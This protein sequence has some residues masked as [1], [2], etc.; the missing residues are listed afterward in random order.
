MNK[1]SKLGCLLLVLLLACGCLLSACKNESGADDSSNQA[2]NA[3]SGT[4][5]P[6]SPYLDENGKC[7]AQT[8]GNTYAG[9]TI[10]FLTCSVNQTYNSEII[11]NDYETAGNPN[12]RLPDVI[13][14]AYGLRNQTVEEQ[15][16]VTIR[17]ECVFD[18]NRK[19]GKMMERIRQDNLTY[20]ADYQ[21]VVPCL[22]DGAKLAQDG[23]L[24]NLFDLPGIQMEAPWW[25]QVFNKEMTIAGQLYFTIGD[26]GTTNKSSTAALTFNKDLYLRNGLDAKYNGTPYDFVRNGTWTLDLALE[27]AKEISSDL[28]TD[29]QIT[30]EDEYGWGGQLDDMWS[31]FYGS[32]SKL[33]STDTPDGYPI[34]TANTQ[35]S[36]A[37]ME[38]MQTLVQDKQ[39][40]VSAN[41]YFNV[42]QWPTVLLRDNFIA[43][44]SLF[45][46]GSLSTPIELGDMEDT[47]GMVPMPKGDETQDSYRSLVNPWVSN[48][49]A[50]P[51]SLPQENYQMISDLLNAMGAASANIVADAYLE[52]CIEYM[53]SRDPDTIEMIDNYILPG[54]GC[55]IGM[56]YAWGGLDTL[57]QK[58]ASAPV[59]TFT[60]EFQAI[61]SMAESEMQETIEFFRAL[62]KK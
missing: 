17:E 37:I 2:S 13:N 23:Q 21:I 51:I 19:G 55:D 52:Q 54:R 58:M 28:N 41:D 1:M 11:K 12:E 62:D 38:K 40:Y 48:C 25:D 43:G 6:A 7:V 30:Y 27:L 56:I 61:Q 9:A 50:V 22:Y 35:R 26:I 53:K 34:L 45:Y 42:V 3:L 31:L 32:E 57:L 10:T 24:I 15:L 18:P 16:G 46:N 59:G 20:V 49:F 14:N 60:S 33:A 39:H 44:K 36:A 5:T 4:Q 47:F 8:S 29:G